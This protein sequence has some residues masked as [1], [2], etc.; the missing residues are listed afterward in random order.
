VGPAVHVH[1]KRLVIVISAGFAS[2]HDCLP[3][4]WGKVLEPITRTIPRRFRTVR[5]LVQP[6]VKLPRTGTH[7]LD[8]TLSRDPRALSHILMSGFGPK[9]RKRDVRSNVGYGGAK[10]TRF[11]HHEFCRS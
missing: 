2:G 11:A 8:M 7:D 5:G 3:F 1:L 6:L 10:R 4:C 9:R